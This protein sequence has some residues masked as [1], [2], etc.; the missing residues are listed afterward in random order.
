MS[1]VL[2]GYGES[3]EADVK[4]SK[5]LLERFPTKSKTRALDCGAGIGRITKHVLLD[6]YSEIDLV[7]PASDLLSQARQF[8]ASDKLKVLYC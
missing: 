2:G 7:E 5:E 1:G 6:Y 3:H 8:V 4:F